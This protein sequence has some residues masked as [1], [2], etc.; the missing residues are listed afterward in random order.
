MQVQV[1]L[2]A[3]L[4]QAAGWSEQMVEL[5]SAATVATLFT[6]LESAHP[7]LNLRG[8]RSIY[9]AINEEFAQLDSPLHAG[10]RVAIF[11]PVSGG[12]A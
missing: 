9:A 7:S 3:T 11:P 12:K 2:F 6:Q 4:R 10:D 5:P 8:R 1:K